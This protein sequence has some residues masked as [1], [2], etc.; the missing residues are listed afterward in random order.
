[1]KLSRLKQ[2]LKS[3]TGY[4][5][6]QTYRVRLLVQL[7]F[8]LASLVICLRFTRFINA[9]ITESVPLPT[10]PPGVEGYLPISGLMGI[11]DWIYQGTL[12]RIHPAATLLLLIFLIISFIFRRAF[13]SWICPIGFLSETLARFG[14]RLF[15]RNFHL[16]RWLDI[17]LRGIKYLLFG[18]F[19]WSI[20]NM[21]P[22]SLQT[23]INSPYNRVADIKMY[24]FFARISPLSVIVVIALTLASIPINGAWCR[25]LCPYG[26]LVGLA[27]WASPFKIRRNMQNCTGCKLCD[28]VCLARLPISRQEQVGSIECSGCLDCVAVCPETNTLI[29]THFNK[30]RSALI[31]AVGIMLLFLMGYSAARLSGNWENSISD[32]EYIDKIQRIDVSEFSHPGAG[33]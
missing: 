30:S 16:P 31:I 21:T 18:F 27:G 25:Y 7:F 6:Y 32:Q 10:R 29:A 13:C 26:A 2:W 11:V 23:F 22:A 1:M 17:P 5:V 12:N 3:S 28:R 9:A 15:G 19:V 8:V 24:L 20:L 33:G 14:Q 4:G